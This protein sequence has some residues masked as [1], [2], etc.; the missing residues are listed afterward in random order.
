[1][2]TYTAHVTVTLRRSILDVQGKTVEHALHSLHMPSLTNVRIGK[3]IEV[4]VMAPDS[5]TAQQ[6]IDDACQKLLTNP[7]ME[8]YS[9]SITESSTGVTA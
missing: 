9:I 2:K 6:L 3:H 4:D 5:E 8:D 1:M 7:V